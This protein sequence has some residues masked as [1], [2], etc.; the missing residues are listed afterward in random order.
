ME[1]PGRSLTGSPC[2][3]L[4][5]AISRKA[6]DHGRNFA[7]Q[8]GLPS[9]RVL[10]VPPTGFEPVLVI[11]L[12]LAANHTRSHLLFR[13]EK[14]ILEY[15]RP[16]FLKRDLGDA[17]V[18]TLSIRVVPR[19]VIWTLKDGTKWSHSLPLLAVGPNNAIHWWVI[20]RNFCAVPLSALD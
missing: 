2:F 1:P 15:M 6:V 5:T 20:P 18:A 17:K 8:L 10:T 13:T 4:G 19:P 16:L 7:L 9:Q 11:W 14:P 12:N 3:S